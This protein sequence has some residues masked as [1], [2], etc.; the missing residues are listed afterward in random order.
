MA[1]QPT[2]VVLLTASFANVP[3]NHNGEIS[4]TLPAT[5]N[6]DATGAICDYD[7]NMLSNLPSATVAGT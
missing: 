6:C 5:T 3:A 7:D 2:P 4:I 1:A